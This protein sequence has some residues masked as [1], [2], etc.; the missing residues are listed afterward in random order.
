MALSKFDLVGL[1]S[2]DFVLHDGEALLLEVNPRPGATLDVLDDETGSLFAAHV[3][4]VQGD[5]PASLLKGRWQPPRAAAAAYLYA[6]Q[7]ALTVPAI[8]WPDWSAD[9]P[10]AGTQIARGQPLATVTATALTS[11]EAENLCRERLSVLAQLVYESSKREGTL[12]L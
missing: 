9:R 2:L 6:D 12:K 8:A 3:A 10:A 4:A 5:N 1:V 7:G 11:P